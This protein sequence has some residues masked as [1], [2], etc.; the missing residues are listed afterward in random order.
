M[1]RFNPTMPIRFFAK[2]SAYVPGEGQTTAW[3]EIEGLY[4]EW[5][6]SYG[7]RTTAAQAL[8]VNESAT[9]RTFYHPNIYEKLRS[10]EVVIAKNGDS[11]VIKNGAPD[12]S[13]PNAYEL[14]GGVDNVGEANQYMEFMVRRYE[15]K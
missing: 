11:T 8:G 2:I 1:I 3:T 4:C 7:D 6:N 5:R 15:G 10:V 13:N 12:K 14:W 9:I